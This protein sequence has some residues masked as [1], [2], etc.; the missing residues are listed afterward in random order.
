VERLGPVLRLS[1]GLVI[2]TS[3]ILVM[4][5]L[6]GLVPDE[7][8]LE[9]ESRIQLSEGLATQLMPAAEIGDFA[10]IR[11]TLDVTGARTEDVL[12]AGLRAAGGR[13]MVA[14]GKHRELWDPKD[15]TRSS[16]TH[17]RLPLF[18]R[19]KEWG[20]VEV[21]FD[22]SASASVLIALW[23]RPLLRLVAAVAVVGFV[24]YMFYM[25]RT[26]RHLDP[27]AVI[28]TRV[29]H[30]LDVM[31]EGVLLLDEHERIVL[32]NSAFAERMGRTPVSL[33][34]VKASGLGWKSPDPESV[35][36]N[37]PWREAIRDA[38]TSTGTRLR[39]DP[40]EGASISF[41]VNA[42]PILD[43]W[44]KPKGCIV[45]FDDQ[46][47][48]EQKSAALEAAYIEIEKSR[49]E[50]QLHN[51]ELE[52]LSK[53]DPLTGVANRRAF[54]EWA[55]NELVAAQTRGARFSVLMCDIDHFKRINDNHGHAAGD[56]VI[57][58]VAD[59]FATEVRGSDS[60]CRYG[61]EEFC[62]AF[63][64]SAV[65]VAMRVAERLRRKIAAPGFTRVPVTMSFGVVSSESGA[66]T[67][68]ELLEQADQ[69]LYA[70]KEG[71][72]D[73]VTRFDDLP[74]TQDA[75]EDPR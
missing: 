53:R 30:A 51:Q 75:P 12:S 5:D 41:A 7:N 55:E 10:A 70:S 29:Q 69:A 19:G 47:E 6:V 16:P 43:G 22:G 67:L 15:D 65:E 20:T 48:L 2:L 62:V 56:D 73:R 71:G 24:L 50:I 21:R 40:E 28:P 66:T 54:M 61:G 8:D 36:L 44:E 26:L 4:A 46:T 11:R 27:S 31:T 35:L 39:F 9:L 63:P 74:E 18:Q 52:V 13:L 45:T 42:S 1:L 3:S 17:V 33:M 68:P 72:R 60:V 37:Y 57:K 59:L 58:S 49:D 23:E 14:A 34:G 64:G 32:A 25:R 38:R